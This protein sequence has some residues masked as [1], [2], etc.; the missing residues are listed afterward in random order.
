MLCVEDGNQKENTKYSKIMD[1]F[2]LPYNRLTNQDLKHYYPQLKFPPDFQAV[3]DPAGMSSCTPY[4]TNCNSDFEL[5][6][7]TFYRK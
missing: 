7:L 6:Q 2:N 3:F 5:R 1:E 4:K